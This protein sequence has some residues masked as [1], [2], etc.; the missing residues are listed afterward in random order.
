MKRFSSILLFLIAAQGVWAQLAYDTIPLKDAYL[1]TGSNYIIETVADKNHT[2]VINEILA[3][4]SETNSDENGD[5]DDWFEV[6]NFGNETL[7]LKDYYFTDDKDKP[8]KWQITS[9]DNYYIAPG[10]FVLF[11]CDNEPNEG[12]LHTNFKLLSSGEFV[13]IYTIENVL[14]D[15][16]EFNEQTTGIS[17][18][19]YPNG[20]LNLYIFTTP[21]PQGSNS[22]IGFN[23]SLSIP[24]SDV[25][26]GFY[27]SVQHVKLS[28]SDDDCDIYYTTDFS[29]PTTQ[30]NLYTSPISVNTTTI[31]RVAAFKTG[32]IQSPVLSLSYIFSRENYENPVISIV[33]NQKDLTGGQGIL[34]GADNIEIPATMEYLV[35]GKTVFTSGMGVKLHSKKSNKQYSMRFYAR[36]RY[37]NSWFKF[38]F[39]DNMAPNKFKRLIIRNSGNDCVQIKTGNTHFRDQL[40]QRMANKFTDN[41]IVSESKPVNVF[42]NGEYFGL[43]NLRERVDEYFVE[44]HFPEQ[45]E[46]DL[47]ERAFGFPGNRNAIEGNWDRWNEILNFV[48]VEGDMSNN[49]DYQIAK[50][51]IDIENFTDYWVTEVIMGNYDWLSNNIKFI[52][53]AEGKSRWIYWDTDHGIGYKYSNYGNPN[54]NT[55]EWSLTFSDRAWSLGQNNRIVRNLLNNPDYKEYFIKRLCY[56]LNLFTPQNI[57]PLIDSVKQLYT[58]DLQYHVQK[59][60]NSIGQWNENIENVKQYVADR[61]DFVFQHAKEFFD[62]DDPVNIEITVEPKMAGV[63]YFGDTT[64]A[65]KEFNGRIFPGLQ[66]YIEAKPKSMYKFVGWE[67]ISSDTN[68]ANINITG[69]MV[70]KAKFE[71]LEEVEPLF[72]NEIC[73]NGNYEYGSGDWIEITNVFKGKK[74]ISGYSIYQN[75]ELLYE[76]PEETVIDSGEFIVIAENPEAFQQVY[77]NKIAVIGKLNSELFSDVEI[78]FVDK[79]GNNIRK[80]I[81]KMGTNSW[82]EITENGYSYELKWYDND[83]GSPQ[84]WQKSVDRFGSP[85]LANGESFGFSL[86]KSVSKTIAIKNSAVHIFSDTLLKY[87]DTDGHDF[88]GFKIISVKGSIRFNYNNVACP[89][90]ENITSQN[91]SCRATGVMGNITRIDYTVLD[92]SGDESMPYQLFLIDSLDWN[93]YVPN[94][95]IYPMPAKSYFKVDIEGFCD[96]K[97]D[98]SLYTFDGKLVYSKKGFMADQTAELN[99]SNQKNGTYILQVRYNNNLYS[100]KVLILR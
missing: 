1:K 78:K 28:T 66:Y 54:W 74:N 11:W 95:T 83:S 87:Y 80:L 84:H 12:D 56:H 99:I 37:G 40:I 21:T 69:N 2:L 16:I 96:T 71:P 23:G 41:S 26:G 43:Y 33:A 81:Y 70:I 91:F 79:S 58:N 60:G 63:V 51:K 32:Y 30:S 75:S 9:D 57:N 94:I 86:P 49:D 68:F 48:D 50:E 67:G 89:I 6:Y 14:V 10:E 24:E 46:Y 97:M 38:P 20:G 82:P 45:E 5:Y 31:L 22:D 92:K 3:T 90:N 77:L 73:F 85:G 100:K 47:L 13:G 35:N 88:V 36:S 52:V 76:F 27:N 59:W 29:E 15:G 62:L 44:T 98:V 61:S 18:G 53:P 4:N 55:L 17:Y 64:V 42:F 39:F 72:I 34:N 7:N 19:R 93:D 65:L 25:Q 8:F